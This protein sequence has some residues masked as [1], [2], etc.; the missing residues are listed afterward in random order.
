M[1]IYDSL[2]SQGGSLNEQIARQV[3]E[4]LPEDGPIMII[5]DR[6]GNCWPSDSGKFN[7]L[8][9]SELFIQ[10]L[11]DKVDD[12]EEPVITQADDYGIVALQLATSQTNCGYLI[13]A[14]PRYSPEST[15]VNID[16]IEIILR[17]VGLIAKLIEKNSML[18]ENQRKQQSVTSQYYHGDSSMN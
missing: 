2:F 7:S 5:T 3:F 16:L 13:L 17:Q 9:L 12:G 4:L 6:G 11:L 1:D 14:L 10:G 8:N 18:C 15:M